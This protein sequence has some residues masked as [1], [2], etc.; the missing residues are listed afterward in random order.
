MIAYL[1]GQF[2][3]IYVFQFWKALTQSKH[4]W[5]RATGSTIL[6]QNHRHGDDQRDFL[7]VGS[8]VGSH[9]FSRAK[10]DAGAR[11]GVGSSR[12]SAV[13]TGSSSS[14]RFSLTPMVYALHSAIVKWLRIEPEAHEAKR[15]RAEKIGGV[16]GAAPDGKH[17][18]RVTKK[19]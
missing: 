17:E 6:S 2:L 13:S 4:L 1:C 16:G 9:W 7:V 15:S 5:L 8:V 11:V 18:S 3:D 12:R 19:S 10:M 14:S